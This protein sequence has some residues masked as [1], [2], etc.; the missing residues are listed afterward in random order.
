MAT[1]RSTDIN[2]T[3]KRLERKL[4]RER[5]ARE[6]AERLLE[7]KSS[8]LYSLNAL[9][10]TQV[11][12]IEVLH[13]SIDMAT[14][15]IALTD[16]DGAFIYMNPAHAA[17]FAY[18]VEEL[19]GQSWT[20]LY[21][22]AENERIGETVFPRLQNEGSWRGETFGLSKTGATIIQEIVLT[23]L[24]SGGLICAARD[25]SARRKREIYAREL[26]G[27][28]Q[29]AER[30]AA[31][32][33]LGNAVAH[34]FNNLIAAISGNAAMLKTALQND[35]DNYHRVNQIEIATRQA[36]NV[37]RSL[38]VERSNETQN[39]APIDLSELIQTGL[40][41][42]EAIKPKNIQVISDIPDEAEIVS[43]EVV[44]TRCLLNIVKNAFEAINGVGTVSL[45][46]AKTRTDT[47]LAA[48]VRTLE[49][50]VKRDDPIW[51]VEITDTGSGVPES[52]LNHIFED[53]FTTKP[54]LVGSGLGLQA[55]R[56]LADT[57]NAFVEVETADN[58]GTR[59]R[60]TFYNDVLRAEPRLPVQSVRKEG[61][62]KPRAGLRILL[63]DDNGLVG[64][65]LED[66]LLQMK[67]LPDWVDD[68][69][70]VLRLI[71]SAKRPYD[72]IITDLSMPYIDGQNLSRQ[73][74]SIRPDLPIIIY[75]GQAS[76]IEQSSIYAAI[77]QKPIGMDE[78][79]VAIRNAISKG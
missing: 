49:T 19:M 26:E 29:K 23:L 56:T 24:P 79:G 12:D 52:K 77:L 41:I 67:F 9:L 53:F 5:L 58:V 78:L 28:L 65:M 42:A 4:V 57:G 76:L 37:I 1:E 44:V 15:G 54:K 68:P 14:D 60:L 39:L 30:E 48:D 17:M 3:L 63:V 45:R 38:N 8:E 34:D 55:L 50:G 69:R 46:V 6:E 43:N 72:L 75:S 32:F 73:I 40:Q 33:T 22:E 74:K 62:G 20:V 10:K 11:Q 36:A 66:A 13:H 47:K 51:I 7:E 64:R 18:T 59:F 31:L 35:F 71:E 2:D 21:G 25:I 27:R 16:S 70:A 61:H